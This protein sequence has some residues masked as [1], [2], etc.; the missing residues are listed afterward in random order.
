MP[1]HFYVYPSYLA[2]GSRGKGRRV[3]TAAASPEPSIDSILQAARS[4]GF[5]AEGEIGKQYPRRFQAES[6]RVKVTKKAGISKARALHEIAR[7]LKSIGG[8]PE[9]AH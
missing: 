5:T 2:R 7:A 6:G 8:E 3:P 1:D 4:L 9:R